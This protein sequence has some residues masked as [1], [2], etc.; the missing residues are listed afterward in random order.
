MREPEP[1]VHYLTT[2]DA[3]RRLDVCPDRVRQLSR[4]GRLKAAIITRSGQRLYDEAEVERYAV[5]VAR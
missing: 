4:S 2:S 1:H 5:Q 3:A